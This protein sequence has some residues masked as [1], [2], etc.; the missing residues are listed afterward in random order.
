MQENPNAQGIEASGSNS[1]VSMGKL[2]ITQLPRHRYN[3]AHP[4]AAVLCQVSSLSSVSIEHFSL[5]C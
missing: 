1:A 2:S 4:K 3:N 5:R